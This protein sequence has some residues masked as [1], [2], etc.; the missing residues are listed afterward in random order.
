MVNEHLAASFGF[1]EADLQANRDGEL[2]EDQLSE[3]NAQPVWK[4]A[5]AVS[6]LVFVVCLALT[7]FS[8]DPI[9]ALIISAGAAVLMFG[10]GLLQNKF[11]GAKVK[12]VAGP[13]RLTQRGLEVGSRTKK[14]VFAAEGLQ[15]TAF[16]PETQ[17]RVY[18]RN[19]FGKQIVLSAEEIA[20]S[21]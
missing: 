12:T 9:D 20:S 11:G 7:W 14:A 21:V 5:L 6:G 16:G 2:S 17:V 1:D 13:A 10:I 8:S 19:S 15:Q 4:G 18:W 3:L